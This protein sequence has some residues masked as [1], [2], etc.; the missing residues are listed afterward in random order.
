MLFLSAVPGRCALFRLQHDRKSRHRRIKKQR[1]YEHLA[2]TSQVSLN[3]FQ[4]QMFSHQFLSFPSRTDNSEGFCRHPLLVN[5]PH[6]FSLIYHCFLHSLTLAFFSPLL[7]TFPSLCVLFI[8]THHCLF[9]C[10]ASPFAFFCF[11]SPLA[12]FWLCLTPC[13]FFGYASS[14]AF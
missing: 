11:A 5:F 1:R 10:Y 2:A 9:F 3:A 12:F 14:L 7:C 4:F 13:F 8:L 6:P